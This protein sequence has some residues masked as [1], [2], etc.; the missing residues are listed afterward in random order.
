[1]FETTKKVEF[2]T[3]VTVAAEHAKESCMVGT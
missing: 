2:D 3:K 1:M